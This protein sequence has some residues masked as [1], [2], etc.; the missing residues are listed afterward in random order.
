MEFSGTLVSLFAQNWK[1]YNMFEYQSGMNVRWVF[2][3]F[4][5]PTSRFAKTNM[6]DNIKAGNVNFM[7]G[8]NES[9]KSTSRW[10]EFDLCRFFVTIFEFQSRY[11]QTEII[12]WS[13]FVILT[14]LTLSCKWSVPLILQWETEKKG[15]FLVFSCLY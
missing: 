6:A 10:F 5:H 9:Q 3:C 1:N 15:T 12:W 14:L 11:F 7:T 13:K 8:K 4:F 2:F